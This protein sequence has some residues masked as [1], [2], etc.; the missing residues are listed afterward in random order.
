[1][2]AD[3][4]Q[5]KGDSNGKES[6]EEGDEEEGREEEEGLVLASRVSAGAGVIPRP[7]LFSGAES[8]D[9]AKKPGE[10]P[11]LWHIRATQPCLCLRRRPCN[12]NRLGWVG[13]VLCVLG[14]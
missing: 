8:G 7:G 6:K 4:N 1:L 13:E 5:P 10:M 2:I 3:V 14:F 9:W 11:V 12:S